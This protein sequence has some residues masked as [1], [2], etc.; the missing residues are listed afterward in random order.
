MWPWNFI[1]FICALVI[2]YGLGY[3]QGWERGSRP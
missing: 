2:G 3:L 1:M